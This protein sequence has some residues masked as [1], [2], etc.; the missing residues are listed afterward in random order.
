MMN[1]TTM[2]MADIRELN[3][4]AQREAAFLQDLVAEISK[5]MVRSG[6][7]WSARVLI[8]LLADG[9]I[10]LEGV[11]GLAKTLLVKSTA[12]A[13]TPSLPASSLRRTCATDCRYADIQS[14]NGR[15]QRPSG[16][17]SPTSS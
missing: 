16:T 8:G 1:T 14:A 9:H 15:I 4:Q 13:M 5:V 17:V 10:L 7:L 12:D 11:P 3:T 2:T 6:K